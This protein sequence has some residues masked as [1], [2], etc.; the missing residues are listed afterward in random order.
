MKTERYLA[1]CILLL[2]WSAVATAQ[3]TSPP[4]DIPCPSDEPCQV[5]VLTATEI[6]VLTAD[7][8]ILA[9]AS[10][11]RNLDLGQYVAYFRQK[12]ALAPAGKNKPVPAV[13]GG[14]AGTSLNG[15]TGDSTVTGKIVPEE[16]KKQP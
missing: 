1:A 4:V 15:V 6:R 13:A 10:Q 16:P 9:T 7:Q 5:L 3:Q 8:G 12:I 11:A 14:S 2:V